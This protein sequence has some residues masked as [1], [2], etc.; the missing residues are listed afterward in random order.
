MMNDP[1][2]SDA[3]QAPGHFEDQ[4]QQ[5]QPSR[6]S[7][8][9]RQEQFQRTRDQAPADTQGQARGTSP[10]DPSNNLSRGTPGDR[11]D[12]IRRR[13]HELW[14]REGRPEGLAQPHWDRAAQDIDREDA[15]SQRQGELAR[16][17]A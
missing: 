7:G 14:E 9:D 11:E 4:G 13:A 8:A 1:E 3:S 16:K 6:P 17:P 5:Q 12:R 2:N 15:E 10:P